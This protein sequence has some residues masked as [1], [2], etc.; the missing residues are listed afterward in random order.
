MAEERYSINIY[1]LEVF[2]IDLYAN[3]VFV[4]RRGFPLSK[5][6][7]LFFGYI[8]FVFYF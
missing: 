7:F 6:S 8:S 1:F 2:D 5:Q 3:Y 4:G